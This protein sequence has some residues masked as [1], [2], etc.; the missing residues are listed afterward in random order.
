MNKNHELVPDH[1]YCQ[2]DIDSIDIASLSDSYVRQAQYFQMTHSK[3]DVML[4]AL[5]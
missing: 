5:N 1:G 3:S 2:S 4:V